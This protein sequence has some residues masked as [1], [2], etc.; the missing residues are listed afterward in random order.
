MGDRVCV[1][2]VAI[3]GSGSNNEVKAETRWGFL[4][5]QFSQKEKTLQRVTLWKMLEMLLS[6]R[7]RSSHFPSSPPL[8]NSVSVAVVAAV[9]QLFHGSDQQ[10]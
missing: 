1:C 9:L 5:F 10:K 3:R 4:L 6:G 7:Q 8:R 2:G